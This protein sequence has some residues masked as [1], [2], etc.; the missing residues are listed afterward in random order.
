M[1]TVL[2]RSEPA[3]D[4]LENT[5]GRQV[6]RVIV[7]D[8]R[9]QAGSYKYCISFVS[10]DSVKNLFFLLPRHY[11]LHCANTTWQ[12]SGVPPDRPA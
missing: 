9:Q 3:R 11:F 6:P 2:C 8:H 7:H 4:E 1:G 10:R 5:A 12:V